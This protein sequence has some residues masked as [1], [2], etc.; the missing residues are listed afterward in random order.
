MNLRCCLRD[1]R[2]R[3]SADGYGQYT[4]SDDAQDPPITCR[5]QAEP[6]AI[7]AALQRF[8]STQKLFDQGLFFIVRH[9]ST[10]LD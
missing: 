1:A 6:P 4:G 7:K 10:L 5:G 8:D 2:V 3:D 9:V